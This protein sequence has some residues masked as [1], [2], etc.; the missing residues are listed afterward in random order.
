MTPLG[1]APEQKIGLVFMYLYVGYVYLYVNLFVLKFA[2]SIG[3]AYVIR[4][5]C[6]TL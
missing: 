6:T 5:V 3:S 4:K 2:H 1:V